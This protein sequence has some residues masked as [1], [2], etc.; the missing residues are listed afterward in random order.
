MKSKQSIILKLCI[1]TILI[2]TI[3]ACT[4][5]TESTTN[6]D[7]STSNT[8]NS[9]N[10]ISSHFEALGLSTMSV[11][12]SS[13]TLTVESDG[14]P[15]H[16]NMAGITGWNQRIA[17]PQDFT[18]DNAFTFPLA[19]ELAT[20]GVKNY[21]HGAI[22]VAINGIPIFVPYKQNLCSNT[23]YVDENCHLLDTVDESD[24]NL[25]TFDTYFQGELDSCGGHSGRG[26]DYHYHTYSDCLEAIMEAAGL[27]PKNHPWAYAYDGFPIYSP[28]P[29][30]SDD[31]TTITELLADLD[32]YNGH[33]NSDGNYHYHAK[34]PSDDTTNPGRPYVT[35]GLAGVISGSYGNNGYE[36][37]NGGSTSG[38]YTSPRDLNSNCYQDT[39]YADSSGLEFTS[40]ATGIC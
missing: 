3:A 33:Y 10:E 25:N 20:E 9:T 14:F 37:D 22:G 6:T 11:S 13:D 17:L 19:P 29:M 7:D 5:S 34:Q 36:I 38:D 4:T 21:I 35:G 8:D 2:F 39:T 16:D 40:V 27:E 23:N 15:T 24:T 26:D 30:D 31:Q 1:L 28:Y 32:E 18:E 12:E